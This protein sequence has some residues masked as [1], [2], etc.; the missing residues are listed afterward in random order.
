MSKT[1]NVVKMLAD[2]GITGPAADAVCY[3]MLRQH[4]PTVIESVKYLVDRGFDAD[5]VSMG[6]RQASKRE[7]RAPDENGIANC[8]AVARHLIRQRRRAEKEENA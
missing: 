8:M 4:S 2:E 7:G 5:G 1:A 3:E 6:M